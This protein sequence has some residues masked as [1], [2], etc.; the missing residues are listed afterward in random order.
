MQPVTCKFNRTWQTLAQVRTQYCFMQTV[1]T[2]GKARGPWIKNVIPFLPPMPGVYM[3]GLLIYDA[4]GNITHDQCLRQDV[5][6][7]CIAFARDKEVTLTAYCGDRILTEA[8]DEHTDR[9]TFFSEPTPEGVYLQRDCTGLATSALSCAN[10]TSSWQ[11]FSESNAYHQTTHHPA[12]CQPPGS[13]DREHSSTHMFHIELLD[14]L[15]CTQQIREQGLMPHNCHCHKPP[16][17]A[18]SDLG[19]LQCQ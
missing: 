1:I 9:L 4:D 15:Y 14:R 18:F 10:R 7:Q 11:G 8:T 6:R 3:Q 12:A 17:V 2:T 5:V 13:G 19:L 16:V